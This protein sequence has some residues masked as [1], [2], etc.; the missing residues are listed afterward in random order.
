MMA[1]LKNCKVRTVKSLDRSGMSPGVTFF[2]DGRW[3]LPH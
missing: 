3:R 1:N 2:G